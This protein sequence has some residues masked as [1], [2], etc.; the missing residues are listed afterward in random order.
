MNIREIRWEGV[1]RISV[2]Q[3]TYQCR[4]LVNAPINLRAS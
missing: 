1:G 2:A 3:D 4:D